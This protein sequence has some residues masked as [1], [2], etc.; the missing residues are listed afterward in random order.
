MEVEIQHS[1]LMVAFIH[2]ITFNIL[3]LNCRKVLTSHMPVHVTYRVGLYSK[4]RFQEH[5][6]P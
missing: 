5:P 6:L 1:V 4:S 3:S 2:C